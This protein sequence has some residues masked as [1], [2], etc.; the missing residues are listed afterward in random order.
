MEREWS[1]RCRGESGK[2]S[3]GADGRIW[4][5]APGWEPKDRC[6]QLGR[7]LDP[8]AQPFSEKKCA[9]DRLP[10]GLAAQCKEALVP[11]LEFAR[12]ASAR[13]YSQPMNNVGIGYDVHR[14]V[15]GRKLILGGIDIPH[16]KGLEG[17]S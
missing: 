11:Q 4:T 15:E 2:R 9:P 14:L 17:H 3:F 10:F 12:S 1:K 13:K 8:P 7:K 6:S 5:V 16:P